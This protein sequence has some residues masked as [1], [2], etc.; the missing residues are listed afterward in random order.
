MHL[1]LEIYRENT[2]AGA[3]TLAWKTPV[4][5][6]EEV[7]VDFNDPAVIFSPGSWRTRPVG[8][9]VFNVDELEPPV[10]TKCGGLLIV[11]KHFLSEEDDA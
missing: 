9:F 11:A 8:P 1:M 5:L 7:E 3:V 2:F 6:H 10:Q 4:E